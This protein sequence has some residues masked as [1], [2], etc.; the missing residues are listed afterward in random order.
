MQPRHFALLIGLPL[1]L[2]VPLRFLKGRADHPALSPMDA[3]LHAR[4]DGSSWVYLS[5]T[6]TRWRQL[7]GLKNEDGF[8]IRDRAILN[9][10]VETLRC[11]R[12][13][14]KSVM[15]D[16]D[17]YINIGLATPADASPATGSQDAP[18]DPTDEGDPTHTWFTYF[19]ASNGPHLGLNAREYSA[20]GVRVQPRFAPR[21]EALV[22][23]LAQRARAPQHPGIERKYL[24]D[25]PHL[26]PQS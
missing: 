15:G 17:S 25:V 13:P 14:A 9:T 18:A 23:Q 6:G 26:L 7:T 12:E 5:G 11:T 4:A 24:G 20:H 22:A 21:F 1:L 10:L 2:L 16:Y 8:L 19:Y 3:Q